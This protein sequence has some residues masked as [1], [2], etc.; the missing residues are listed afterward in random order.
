M[1]CQNSSFWVLLHPSAPKIYDKEVCVY[2]CVCVYTVLS[3]QDMKTGDL[4]R[5][6]KEEKNS[7]SPGGVLWFLIHSAE[8]V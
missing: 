8:W 7:R 1:Y 2:V 3:N 5:D 6:Q 4:D